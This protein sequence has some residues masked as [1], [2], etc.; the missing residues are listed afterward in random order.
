MHHTLKTRILAL[1]LAFVMVMGMPVTTFATEAD[2][3]PVVAADAGAH[4]GNVFFS[5]ACISTCGTCFG[6]G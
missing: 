5:Q 4:V 6:A 3:E 2:A 1:L